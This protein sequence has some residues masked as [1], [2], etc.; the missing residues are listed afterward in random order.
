[1]PG[2]RYC[3]LSPPGYKQTSVIAGEG[4]RKIFHS[5]IRGRKC[6]ARTPCCNQK[7]CAGVWETDPSLARPS[8]E[9]DVG[10]IYSTLGRRGRS[11]TGTSPPI[12]GTQALPNSKMSRQI[13]PSQTREKSIVPTMTQPGCLD[14]PPPA[15]KGGV[16]VRN[17]TRGRG[18]LRADGAEQECWE[19]SGSTGHLRRPCQI[20]F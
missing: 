11:A 6:G 7:G 10:Q 16:Q 9:A 8:T 3:E 4:R 1:M 2:K 20:F 13:R 14:P 15:W 12:P 18:Q 19:K 5:W 17:S